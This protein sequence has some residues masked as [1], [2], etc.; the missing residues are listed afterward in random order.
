ML[1][2]R[3][4]VV[5]VRLHNFLVSPNII[6]LPWQCPLTNWK[7]R[8]RSI[9]CTQSFRMVKRLRKLVQYIVRYSTK[10]ASFFAVSYQMFTNELCQLWS[11]WT[12]V[13]EICM[14]YR[15]IIYAVNAH[16]KVAISH[17]VSECRS[18]EWGDFAI[19][20][21]YWLPIAMAT[22][23][24]ISEKEAQIDHLHPN[25][26]IWWKD[27]KNRSSRSWDNC[28]LRNY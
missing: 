20:L 3:M 15:G 2:Q 28:S 8:C 13:H 17:S 24:G 25:A 9:I 4:Q 10:Y 16:I 7:I 18:D 1:V 27:C 14:R 11:Y 23:L 19:F 26:F 21:Q 6:W 12:E 22:S 5:S